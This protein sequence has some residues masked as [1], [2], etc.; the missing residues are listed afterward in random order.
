MAG[1]TDPRGE[2][3]CISEE[4]VQS[5]RGFP[6]L[7]LPRERLP[8]ARDRREAAQRRA[9]VGE[10]PDEAALRERRR[11]RDAVERRGRPLRRKPEERAQ[12][13]VRKVRAG[14]VDASLT[15]GPVTIVRNTCR[16]S[17]TT[18]P[19]TTE[20]VSCSPESQDMG[21]TVELL[22]SNAWAGGASGVSA[23]AVGSCTV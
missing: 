9:H 10:R 6:L 12:N 8:V 11:E 15:T 21:K 13:H 19:S 23:G 22:G 17:L 5:N 4:G 16:V 7:K 3:S 14:D 1:R 20:S 18:G 2:R